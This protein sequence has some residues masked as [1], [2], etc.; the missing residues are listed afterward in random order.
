MG[1]LSDEAIDILV[2]YYRRVPSPGTIVILQQLGNA[3]RRVDPAATAFSHRNAHYD[4]VIVPVWSDPADDEVHIRWARELHDAIE[5]YSLRAS[6]VNGV[7]DDDQAVATVKA[8]F[9]P[10]TLTRLAALKA[11][12]DPTNFLRLNP[13][14]PPAG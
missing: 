3:A 7:S 14:I 13:N 10:E 12:Y 11:K 4:L 8:A 5:P 6:Y 2:D 1:D 9:R